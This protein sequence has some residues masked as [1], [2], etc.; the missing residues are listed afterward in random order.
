MRPPDP[1]ETPATL[2]VTA[3]SHVFN[4]AAGFT[5]RKLLDFGD[6]VLPVAGFNEAV[7][8][9]ETPSLTTLHARFNEAAG[10]TRRK[11]KVPVFDRRHRAEAAGFTRD[12]RS[13]CATVQG[14]CASMRPPDLPGGN[15]LSYSPPQAK[16]Y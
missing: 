1:A 2:T 8:P 3:V 16:V 6:I 5:R 4:E 10:F 11:H 15:K 12:R 14:G 13:S 9:T 7:Y